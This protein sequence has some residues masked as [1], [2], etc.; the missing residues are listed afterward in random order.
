MN[1]L[2]SRGLCNL[3]LALTGGLTLLSGL[4]LL[5]HLKSRPIV[6]IHE[7]GGLIFAVVCLIH[8]TL[9]TKPMLKTI[10]GRT[11]A[12]ALLAALLFSGLGMALSIDA[13]R[14]PGTHSERAAVR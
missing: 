14:M 7:W 5:F 6:M 8:L 10:G 1:V 12:W 4:L 11:V 13:K 9:N 2:S 3:G